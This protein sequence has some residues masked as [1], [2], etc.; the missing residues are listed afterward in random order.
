VAV[1]QAATVA[2][3]AQVVAVRQQQQA[4]RTQVAAVAVQPTA[5][6]TVA[7]AAQASFS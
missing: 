4:Q 5:Q 7:T 3:R 1:A 6:T 2:Q